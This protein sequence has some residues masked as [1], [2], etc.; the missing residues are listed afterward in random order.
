MHPKCQPLLCRFLARTWCKCSYFT[1]SELT[2]GVKFIFI[3]SL[4]HTLSDKVRFVPRKPK[5]EEAFRTKKWIVLAEHLLAQAHIYIYGFFLVLALIGSHSLCNSF[6]VN[7]F[8]FSHQMEKIPFVIHP[9]SNESNMVG[10]KMFCLFFISKIYSHVTQ[11]WWPKTGMV[12][13]YCLCWKL[14]H[15]RRKYSDIS[16]LFAKLQ[17]AKAPES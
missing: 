17:H 4:M 1:N 5:P 15:T 16:N 9:R 8:L 14:L 10:K 13:P 3:I 6:V 12:I 7:Q 11:K 2:L